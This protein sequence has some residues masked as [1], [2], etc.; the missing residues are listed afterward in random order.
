MLQ[1]YQ[2]VNK[3]IFTVDP[4]L[5]VEGY[6]F[7]GQWVHMSNP[8]DREIEL[9]AKST[10][11]PEDMIKAALDEEER[12]RI[13]KEDDILLALTDIPITEDD[14]DHYT[15]QPFNVN[16]KAMKAGFLMAILKSAG[17]RGE[18]KL[19]VQGEGL[20]FFRLLRVQ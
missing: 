1:V 20:E 12:A 17:Q 4:D 2:K 14:G 18:V 11:V 15:D 7:S 3:S 5:I 13:E 19:K 9:V 16:E 6:D 8:T 10:G